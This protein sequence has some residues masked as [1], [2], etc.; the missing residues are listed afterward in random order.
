MGLA[1]LATIIMLIKIYPFAWAGSCTPGTSF[2]GEIICSSKGNWHLSWIFR[3][4]AFG[5]LSLMTYHMIAAFLLPLIYGSW[6]TTLYAFILGPVISFLSTSNPNE[7]PAVWCLI[8]VGIIVIIIFPK[9]R[10]LLRVKRWY[11][12]GYPHKCEKCKHWWIPPDDKHPAKCPR[13]KSRYWHI[14]SK[15]KKK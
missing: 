1:F 8:S 9:A 13:C 5:G 6:K 10:E 15:K 7:W 14:K 3:L 4:N 12:W 2:C 11:F